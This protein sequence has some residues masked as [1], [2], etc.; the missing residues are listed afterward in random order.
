[1]FLQ[2]TK[3]SF[4]LKLLL[5]LFGLNLIVGSS[6]III[7]YN[8]LISSRKDLLSKNIASLAFSLSEQ[9]KPA[10]E[11]DDKKTIEEIIDGTLSYPGAEFV[12]IWKTDPFERTVRHELYFNKGKKGSANYVREIKSDFKKENFIEWKTDRVNFGRVIF[13]GKVPIGFLYLSENL[14]EQGHQ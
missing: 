2:K 6:I 9:I 3:L 4:R 1:M 13:S 5:S 12:G 8:D 10:L 7:A 11:F 14:E